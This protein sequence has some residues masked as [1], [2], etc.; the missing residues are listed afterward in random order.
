MKTLSGIIMLERRRLNTTRD[1]CEQ[2]LGISGISVVV[3]GNVSKPSVGVFLHRWSKNT[4]LGREC[5]VSCFTACT[6]LSCLFCS[7]SGPDERQTKQLR[8][9]KG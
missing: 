3:W 7:G 1:E 5:A 6:F 2:I 4:Q 9:V 8:G